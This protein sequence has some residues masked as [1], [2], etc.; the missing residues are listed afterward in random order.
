MGISPTAE[1]RDPAVKPGTTGIFTAGRAW[2]AAV[3]IALCAAA[4]LPARAKD[5]LGFR[6]G[7]SKSPD[8]FVLGGQAEF[9]PILGPAFFVPSLDAGFG[10]GE[11][12]I[13]LN[14]D[15]RWYLLPLPDT[16]IR[17]Y[18]QAGPTLV[19]SPGTDLGLSLVAGADIPMKR[20]R[21]YN[22]E[23]R[24]GFGDVPDLKVMVGILFGLK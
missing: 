4:P 8:Q 16:G 9:G 17:F 3:V 6:L 7:L 13:A 12:V 23:M 5:G 10:D 22:V 1:E 24:F 11:S 21:R 18:G 14:G 2:V 15:L 19:L 20:E